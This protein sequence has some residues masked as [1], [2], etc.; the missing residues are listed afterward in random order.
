VAKKQLFKYEF[1]PGFNED[2]TQYP[3][4]SDLLRN[5]R[6]FLQRQVSAF[7]AY[8]VANDISPFVEYTYNEGKCQRDFNYVLDALEEDLKFDANRA[9][10]TV[11]S[12]YWVEN[13]P[14]IDGDRA[15]EVAVY[16]FVLDDLEKIFAGLSVTTLY[17]T[18]VPQYGVGTAGEAGAT[19]RIDNLLSILINV[20]DQGTLLLDSGG[21]YTVDQGVGRYGQIQVIGNYD[22]SK[23]L[24]VNNQS[25]GEII[26]NFADPALGLKTQYQRYPINITTMTLYAK[27]ETMNSKDSLQI[28]YE[29]DNQFIKPQAVYQDPVDKMRVS[30]PQSLIDTDFEYSLQPFKWETVELMNNRP[31]VYNKANEPFLTS[32]QIVAMTLTASGTSGNE[33]TAFTPPTDNG[34]SGLSF[35][36]GTNG[37]DAHTVIQLPWQIT[38]ND[39]LY[40][41]VWLSSNSFITLLQNGAAPSYSFYRAAA[42]I[43]NRPT[44]FVGA[45]DYPNTNDTRGN[46]YYSGQV[47]YGS[48]GNCFVLRW[49]G[50]NT[51]FQSSNRIWEAV[52]PEDT[53]DRIY[54]FI[55]SGGNGDTNPGTLGQTYPQTQFFAVSDGNGN[56]LTD[57]YYWNESGRPGFAA[58]DGFFYGGG[59]ITSLV[60]DIETTTTHGKSVGEPILVKESLNTAQIDGAYIISNVPST[61]VFQFLVRDATGL[62]QNPLTG[63]FSQT[64]NDSFITCTVNSHPYRIGS[65]VYIEFSDASLNDIYEVLPT[66]LPTTS[67]FAIG[68][69]DTAAR[70]GTITSVTENFR[71]SYTSI[72]AGGFY[73]NS[74]FPSSVITAV[75]G[76][77]RAQVNFTKPHG[78]FIGT[79]IYVID[80]AN[81]TADFIGGFTVDGV[82]SDTQIQYRTRG[83]EFTNSNTLT[84]AASIYVRPEGNATHRIYDGGVQI[85]PSTNAANAQIIRQTRKY[86]RYQSGKGIQFSTGVLFMPTYDI[87]DVSVTVVG[88]DT[89]MSIR[90]EQEHGFVQPLAGKVLSPLVRLAGFTVTSG[91]NIY[92]GVAEI[93]AVTDKKQFIIRYEN[94]QASDTNPGGNATIEV[95]S[96]YDATVRSGLFDE[97]NGLFFEHDGTDL[98]AVRRSATFQIR[99]TITAIVGSPTVYGYQ[100]KFLSSVQEGDFVNIRGMTHA[101]VKIVS[102]T[103]LE[104][105]PEFRGE[106]NITNV[107]MTAIQE[108]RVKQGDFNVDPLDG[109][110]PSGYVFDQ[111]KMQMVYIDYSWYGAGRVR[112]G[113]RTTDG[114]VAI[115]H[116]QPNNNVNTEAYMRSGNLPGRFEIQNRSKKTALTAVGASSR[117]VTWSY[118][119]SFA[120]TI[121]VTLTSHN[122]VVGDAIIITDSSDTDTLANTAYGVQSV[123]DA[124]TIT[125][126]ILEP[127]RDPFT[128]TANLQLA[129]T[130]SATVPFT[131][132]VTDTDSFPPAGVVAINNEYLRYTKLDE[133]RLTIQERNL[134][135]KLTN[136]NAIAGDN[137]YSVNQN[138]APALSH[139][140]TSVIMDG[141]FDIDKS[142]LF[143][144]IN[145]NTIS[146]AANATVPLVSLRLAPSVDYGVARGFGVRNLINRSLLTLDTVGVSAQRI[147]IITIKLNSESVSF[148][149]QNN[150][151]PAGNGSIAQYFDHSTTT[152]VGL[153]SGDKIFEFFADD[154]NNRYAT[155][156][157]ELNVIRELGNSI[158]GGNNIFPDGPDIITVYAKNIGGTTGNILGRVS[159]SESQG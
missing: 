68:S 54:I 10:R 151:V 137:V 109:T 120:L 102:D 119:G 131:L 44:I 39:T 147:F 101:I 124:N 141:K 111:N 49:I 91:T 123:V 116:E 52:F 37:D 59:G 139:W 156:E 99:G 47:T 65:S 76:S 21:I 66:P 33:L 95:R 17:Q 136:A 75:N 106:I 86:F 98:W 142:Y 128:G 104:I 126:L 55:R 16:N 67:T 5:N 110:G 78:L 143:T 50:G 121:T 19:T 87:N 134:Y 140:G 113:M 81:P 22:S 45:G 36:S 34:T 154:G 41:H 155:T 82:L 148:E 27:T 2:I 112:W 40:T 107:K 38:I 74:A 158:L 48:L 146:C 12:F 152:A 85:T 93:Y 6:E 69:P 1:T 58:G 94:V 35:G 4:A 28:F 100:T 43:P 13:V 64:L 138:F 42:N 63:S 103:E 135:S 129:L 62:Q 127:G 153:T 117:A 56:W 125:V 157:R 89:F 31:S 133:N 150:W 46:G 118:G 60:V 159:W 115:C 73:E 149:N 92:N 32:D 29:D 105:S 8:N 9:T 11:S 18:E 145:T 83:A 71:G 61:T 51:Y 20:I 25:K 88:S 108:V 3:T 14:Q 77:S 23:M 24:L 97:Q 130:A 70:S 26:Y 132:N 84:S 57:F 114:S 122:L 90:T 96:W 15:P 53:P 7:L 30:E 80:N 72:Y 79:P 144:A